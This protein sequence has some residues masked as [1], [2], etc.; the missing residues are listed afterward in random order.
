MS[1]ITLPVSLNQPY[2]KMGRKLFTHGL[3]I[4][5]WCT[6]AESRGEVVEVLQFAE[7]L[8]TCLSNALMLVFYYINFLDAV[9]H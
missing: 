5:N 6:K 1:F 7:P 9:F 2:N 3:C 8:T 4:F